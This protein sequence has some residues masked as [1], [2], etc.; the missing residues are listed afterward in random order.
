MQLRL[1]LGAT[2]SALA[3]AAGLG[4][5]FAGPAAATN[6]IKVCVN[7]PAADVYV[8]AVDDDIRLS[9]VNIGGYPAGSP[10]DAPTSGT[11]QIAHWD[12]GNPG[13]CMELH[14]GNLIILDTCLGRASEE[15]TAIATTITLGQQ[16]VTA[17]YYENEYRPALCLTSP[18][19]DGTLYGGTC[20][21][22]NDTN[23]EWFF[24]QL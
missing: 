22:N 9:R 5:A 23:Q 10:Y 8:C 12:S 19:A 11:H 4:V 1:R 16:T 20:N 14:T 6:E 2:A 17:Y 13:L 15:W 3:L 7:K 18:A 24:V 21:F